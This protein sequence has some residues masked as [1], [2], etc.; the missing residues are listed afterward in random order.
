[1][2]AFRRNVCGLLYSCFN[3]KN[4]THQELFELFECMNAWEYHSFNFH[5]NGSAF[6]ECEMLELTNIS[7]YTVRIQWKS[8]C[9]YKK[10]LQNSSVPY[11]DGG[12]NYTMFLNPSITDTFG[13][14]LFSLYTEVA[15]VERLFYTCTNCSFGAWP[16]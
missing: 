4:H 13:E 14:Q 8:D 16:L 5:F 15:F 2:R 9:D 10:R 7:H 11:W 12:L 6:E 3:F 1:M